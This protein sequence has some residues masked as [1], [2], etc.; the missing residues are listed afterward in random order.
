MKT[1]PDKWG[2]PIK[3]DLSGVEHL[4]QL[5]EVKTFADFPEDT[6]HFI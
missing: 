4:R 1:Q 2:T 5:R 3:R 6:G